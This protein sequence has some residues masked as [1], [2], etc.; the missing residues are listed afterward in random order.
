VQ[1]KAHVTAERP[2]DDARPVD[3]MFFPPVFSQNKQEVVCE[4]PDDEN[5]FFE[6]HFPLLSLKSLSGETRLK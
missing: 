4:I 2:V 1:W 6:K 5:S 3:D